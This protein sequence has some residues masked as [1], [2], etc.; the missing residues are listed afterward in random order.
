MEIL[1]H[2]WGTGY[3]HFFIKGERVSTTWQRGDRITEEWTQPE[4]SHFFYAPL[5][6]AASK[7]PGERGLKNDYVAMSLLF[8]DCDKELPDVEDV[9]LRPNYIVHTSPGRGHLLYLL[10][11]P[12][13]IDSNETRG[14]AERI[15]QGLTTA[16]GGDGAAT[17]LG[18]LGRVVGSLNYKIEPPFK[19]HLEVIDGAPL[20]EWEEL[21]EVANSVSSISKNDQAITKSDT[22]EMKP[23]TLEGEDS[24]LERLRSESMSLAR[25][26]KSEEWVRTML[27]AAN[28]AGTIVHPPYHDL[29]EIDRLAKTAVAKAKTQPKLNDGKPKPMDEDELVALLGYLPSDVAVW[30]HRYAATIDDYVLALGETG[31][32]FRR[33]KLNGNIYIGAAPLSDEMFAAIRM[34]MDRHRY[35]VKDKLLPAIS[36]KA[37]KVPFHPMLEW[38]ESEPWDGEDNIGKLAQYLTDKH[39]MADV[40]MRR[41]CIGS[42]ARMLER[43][44]TQN[45]MWVFEG[46]QGVGKSEFSRFLAGPLTEYYREGGIDADSTDA[47]LRMLGLWI[48]EVGELGATFRKSDRDALKFFLTTQRVTER[49]P[50]GHFDING[51]PRTSFIGTINDEGGFLTDPTGNRRYMISSF[52]DI[53]WSYKKKVDIQQVWAQALALY[54]DKET[55]N[56]L[57][58]EVKMA[59]A[60]NDQ[61]ETSNPED[62][63]LRKLFKIDPKNLQWFLSN[64]AI[65]SAIDA[66]PAPAIVGRLTAQR[67]SKAWKR[68]G[69]NNDKRYNDEGNQERGWVGL[70]IKSR[71]G[72][73]S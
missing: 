5:P 16:M 42:V 19:V 71:A 21:V 3:G 47:K 2:A 51:I 8:V 34:I 50:Y 32:P 57:P 6:T 69:L 30:P 4:G 45:R 11:E 61:Y 1:R 27:H 13:I 60:I 64:D 12:F 7:P 33:N 58:D 22:D 49:K 46:D 70:Q 44:G 55:W 73:I 31:L 38:W 48:N 62:D 68:M 59:D 25:T 9:L 35:G 56:L 23:V 29:K 40:W 17:D 41:W 39:G 14:E 52:S 15:V 43:E 63:Y 37:S 18:H 10:Q 28:E 54:R 67:I 20:R 66:W 36:V 24:R 53:D 65:Y 72:W 26:G